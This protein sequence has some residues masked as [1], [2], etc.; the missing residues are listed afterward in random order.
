MTIDNIQGASNLLSLG[1]ATSQ[2]E[3]TTNGSLFEDVLKTAT[4]LL[5][6][7]DAAEKTTTQL[8]Y[9]FMTGTNDNIYNLLIAQEKSNILLNFTMQIRNNMLSAYQEIMRISV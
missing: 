8:T 3:T 4:E 5:N 9:D 7:T 1:N 2:T 6:A